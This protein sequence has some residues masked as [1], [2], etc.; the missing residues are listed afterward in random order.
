MI[1]TTRWGRAVRNLSAAT[2]LAVIS[3]AAFAQET[4]K[5]AI[6]D[7][8]PHLDTQMTTA[9][10]TTIVNLNMMETLYAFN[11]AGEAVPF[12]VASDELSEDGLTA[13]LTLRDDVKFHNG[14]TMSAQDV[15]DSLDRWGAHGGRGKLLYDMIESVEA[16]GDA[17]VTITFKGVFGPWK[18]LLAFVNGG[19]AIYPSEIIKDRGPEPLAPEENIGTG[20]FKFGEWRPNRYIEL[21][22]FEEYAPHDGPADGYAGGH[23]ALVDKLQFIAVPDVGTRVSGVQAGDYDYAERITGD[24][25]AELNDDPSVETI[26]HGAPTMPLLFFNSAGGIFKENFALRRAIMAALTPSEAM[27]IA[28]GPEDLWDAQGAFYPKGNRWYTEGGLDSFPQQGDPDKARQ[29]AEEAGYKGEPIRF[30]LTTSYPIMYDTG[31]VLVQQMKDAGFN[32]D[33][34]IYDWPTL[35]NRRAETDLWDIFETTHGAVPDPSLFTFLNDNYPGWWT[36]P[37]KKELEAK[38]VG[39]TDADERMALWTDLQALA[40][41]QVPVFKPG[42]VYLYDIHGPNL[43]GLPEQLLI[44]PAFYGVAKN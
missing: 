28:A 25:Y 31:N 4:L 1:G 6:T 22:K 38:F 37:E 8:P 26:R 24:L 12:L 34:Q 10:L 32:I 42:D 2:A 18:N 17:E 29:M 23:E 5:V 14:D 39:T 35:V 13:V 15:V 9:T 44:W 11:E 16:T 7:E 20:P 40:Y 21:T 27:A 33:L 41:E 19:P 36:S 3:G 43:E 30:M